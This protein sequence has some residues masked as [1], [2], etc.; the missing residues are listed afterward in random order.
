MRADEYLVL[1]YDKLSEGVQA[2]FDRLEASAAFRELFLKDP[3]GTMSEVILGGQPSSAELN[4]A[5]RLLFALL[6]NRGFMDWATDYQRGLADR[7]SQGGDDGGERLKLAAAT[8]DRSQLYGDLVRAIVE[9]AD[10]ETMYSIVVRGDDLPSL[11]RTPAPL[12]EVAVYTE[13]FIAGYV[14]ALFFLVVTQIDVSP[15]APMEAISRVDLERVSGLVAERLTAQAQQLR[16]SG[17]L[18][19]LDRANAG[20]AVT[21]GGS[22]SG[23]PT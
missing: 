13:T 7:A 2:F 10:L 4:Q 21:W 1:H 9:H 6:G 22:Q 17:A 12:P 15:E 8:L 16:E 20:G 5:N 18:T 14:V 3:A 23:S 19:D 11:A